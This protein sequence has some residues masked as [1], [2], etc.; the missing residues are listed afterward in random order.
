MFLQLAR[1]ETDLQC[2]EPIQFYQN[3]ST[4]KELRDASNQAESLVRSFGVEIDMRVDVFNAKKHAAENIK[5][6]GVK[7]NSE[8]RRLVE[9]MILDGRRAGLDLPEDKREELT[10]KKKQLSNLCIEFSVCN[11][12]VY[13]PI[14]SFMLIYS[15]HNYTIRKTLM[16]KQLVY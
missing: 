16:R 9:K 10:A 3:V 14:P 15:F 12:V 6:Q 7:L 4:S 8:E 11:L 13:P 5:A 1:A 2:L